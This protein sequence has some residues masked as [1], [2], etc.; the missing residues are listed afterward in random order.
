MTEFNWAEP[1]KIDSFLTL[2]SRVVLS[3]MEGIMRTAFC[4]AAQDLGIVQNW[5][6]PFFSISAQSVPPVRFFRKKLV[7]YRN[8]YPL[9][10]QLLGHD[11]EALAEA[12][13]RAGEA[14]AVGINL[15]MACPSRTVLASGNG[16]G[17][18]Q[19]L[20]LSRKIL[21]RMKNKTAQ[22]ISLS[23]KLRTGWESPEEIPAIVSMLNDLEIPWVICHFRTVREG[24]R[25]VDDGVFRL[26][27]FRSLLHPCTKMFGNGDVQTCADAEKMVAFSGCDGVAIGRAVIRNPFLFKRLRMNPL[28]ADP[29]LDSEQ[30]RMER[31]IFLKAILTVPDRHPEFAD[32]WYRDSFLECCRMALGRESEL[33]RRLTKMSV[34]EMRETFDGMV[35][36]I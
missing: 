5:I 18:L 23:V 6:T 30:N 14:G 33:F 9:T 20:V 28:N 15:N 22:R 29:E 26:R 31:L 2:P 1:L 21:E 24:Y 7:V 19:D 12:A 4:A 10:V 8:E 16:G 36:E 25:P 13:C 32:E 35:P 3:P 27:Q 11:P 34:K 17:L